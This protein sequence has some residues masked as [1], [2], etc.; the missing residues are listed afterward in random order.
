M[1]R[2]PPAKLSLPD[3]D[4]AQLLIVGDVMLDWYWHGLTSRISPEAPVPVVHV[5]TEE[6]RVGGAGNVALNAAA[7]GAHV[8][9]LGLAGQD[10]HADRMEQLLHEGGVECFLQRVGGSKTI[11]KLR[12]ISHHQ[13][14]IRADF[15][16]HFPELNGDE[17]MF[18]F[19]HQLREVE[20]VVLSDYAKGALRDSIKL[21][22]AARRAGKPVI[23]DPKGRDFERYR[24]ATVITPNL[25]EFEAVVGRC[26]SETDIERKGVALRDALELDA[27]LVTRSEK[28]MTLIARGHAPLHLPTR[29]REVFDVTG[30][31][32]TV[33]ATLSA[34]LG[35]GIP[36]DEAVALSNVAAGIVVAKLGTATVGRPELQQAIHQDPHSA[37][38]G[39][40]LARVS[41]LPWR[42]KRRADK[43][44]S[45]SN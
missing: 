29:A 7:L 31:G 41:L 19:E 1:T 35:A 14:M 37:R 2:N 6:T 43:P 22:S 40:M 42:A 28:G 45:V 13:Q 32:D 44:S 24:G 11:T 12:I 3:F 26:E 5:Q 15:E 16:D 17:L 39:N 21:I 20:A 8:R 36:L 34:A 25:S 23:V 27:V 30:A 38:R 9:L 10:A 18:T 33:V 4:R